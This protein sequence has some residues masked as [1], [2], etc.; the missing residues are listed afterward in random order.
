M[1]RLPTRALVALV[2]VATGGLLLPGAASAARHEDTTPLKLPGAPTQQPQDPNSAGMLLR[3]LLALVF[4]LAVV[5]G[6]YR[7]LRWLRESGVGALRP[8]PAVEVIS[9]TP[10]G[11]HNTAVLVV[12][13][14]DELLVLACGDRHT[15]LLSRLSLHDGVDQGLASWSPPPRSS[16]RDLLADLRQRLR[17]RRPE[18]P[19]QL[20]E[21]TEEAS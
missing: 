16:L 10:L 4:V 9:R 2:A 17:Q 8:S 15:T 14:G 7:L 6:L 5:Y 18:A 11:Q 13:T 3:G 20:D 21:L 19:K 12:R 1:V